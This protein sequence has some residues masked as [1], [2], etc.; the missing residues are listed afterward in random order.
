MSVYMTEEEQLEAIKQWWKKYSGVITVALSVILLLAAGYRYWNWHQEKV[1]LQASAAYE[2]MIISFTNAK[3][4]DSQ[5]YANQLISEYGKTSYAD[6]ARMLLAKY[7]VEANQYAKARVYLEQVAHSAAMPA[8]QRVA[9]TRLARLLMA[10]KQYDSAL[11]TLDT[12]DDKSYVP[13]IN[14]L[15]GDIFTAKGDTHKALK[16]Y[17]VAVKA[18][19][20]TNTGNSFLEMKLNELASAQPKSVARDSVTHHA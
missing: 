13:L 14:E 15:K 8:L 3:T 5:S 1:A 7:L 16:F 19:Q 10:D 18:S 6:S 4:A 12:I 20:E 9:K 17:T 11:K 2:K